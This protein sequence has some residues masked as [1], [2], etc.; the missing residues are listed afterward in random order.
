MLNPIGKF[1][2]AILHLKRNWNHRFP[3]IK[4]VHI[5][6]GSFI[7]PPL[8][9]CYPQKKRVRLLEYNESNENGNIL[10]KVH[11]NSHVVFIVSANRSA[12]VGI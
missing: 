11:E 2:V 12:K 1:K 7:C 5:H 6:Y 4:K 8:A 3:D 9:P 10:Q